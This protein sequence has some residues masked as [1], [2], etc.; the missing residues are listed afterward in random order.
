MGTEQEI[1]VKDII[2]KVIGHPVFHAA[3]IILAA[4]CADKFLNRRILKYV[5]KKIQNKSEENAGRYKTIFSVISKII[6]VIIAF[7]TVVWVLQLLFNISPASLIAATGIAG[8]ALG[9]GA[10]SLVKDSINGFFILMEDQ[11]NVGDYVTIEGF[12][13]RVQAVSLRMTCVESF[14]GDRMYIPNGTISRVINHSKENRNVIISIP[15]SYDENID[16][17]IK[18]MEE[19]AAGLKDKIDCIIDEP[20]VLGVDML[21]ASSVNIKLVMPCVPGMQYRCRREALRII[22][23]EM[24]ERGLEIPYAH[25]TIINKQ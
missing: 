10:Q 6:T 20:T 25:M 16:N 8:A 11:F 5:S 21:D 12:E 9:L 22:R 4:V 17:A 15:V 3:V 23:G 7:L 14:D 13:G 18:E 2:E 19:I 24:K 1:F